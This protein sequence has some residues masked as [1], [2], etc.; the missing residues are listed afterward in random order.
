[1]AKPGLIEAAHRGTMFLD[2]IGDT[3]LAISRSC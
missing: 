1:M 2:E 3:D